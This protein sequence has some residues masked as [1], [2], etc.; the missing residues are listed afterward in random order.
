MEQTVREHKGSR[1][2]QGEPKNCAEKRKR[3]KR[4]GG[5]TKKKSHYVKGTTEIIMGKMCK[6]LVENPESLLVN[7]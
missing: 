1:K 6:P 5:K 2:S 7:V 4:E 3:K